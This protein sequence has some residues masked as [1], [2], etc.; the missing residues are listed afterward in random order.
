MAS[1][2]D[3]VVP[4]RKVALVERM[5]AE[6][7]Q[8]CICRT[9]KNILRDS[10]RL[11]M[12]TQRTASEDGMIQ[13]VVRFLNL[14]TGYHPK[15]SHFWR[16]MVIPGIISRCKNCPNFLVM[17]LVYYEW[18][19][20]AD[21]ALFINRFGDISLSSDERL[22]PDD[23]SELPLLFTEFCSH[24]D[25][26]SLVL[27]LC[28]R[29]GT[30]KP[31]IVPVSLGRVSDWHGLCVKVCACRRRVYGNSTTALPSTLRLLCQML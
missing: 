19:L 14:V 11:W 2:C 13:L 26:T 24:D 23:E 15:A 30:Y 9:L 21:F 31:H 12:C 20:I 1:L 5:L 28:N 8:E 4:S 17:G 16:T 10:M 3:A 18:V 27:N 7:L 22:M 29:T 6:L 25:L